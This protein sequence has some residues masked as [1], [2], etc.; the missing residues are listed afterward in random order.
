MVIV[1]LQTKKCNSR[2]LFMIN[3]SNLIDPRSLLP[4][5][6]NYF[7]IQ[8]F[9]SALNELTRWFYSLLVYFFLYLS[10]SIVFSYFFSVFL[11]PCFIS[12]I[13]FFL[14]SILNATSTFKSCNFFSF[15]AIQALVC[16]SS[17]CLF[18]CFVFF[19]CLILSRAIPF[20]FL[21]ILLRLFYFMHNIRIII[22]L[23]VSFSVQRLFCCKRN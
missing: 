16:S 13:L 15:D 6:K 10:F 2:I 21:L 23:G 3:A 11:C 1:V 19:P 12:T 17:A 22:I 5:T 4:E 14:T 9:S 20:Y 18:V 7:L 8:C